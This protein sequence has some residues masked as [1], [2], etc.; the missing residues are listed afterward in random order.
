MFDRDP[1]VVMWQLIMAPRPR[2]AS[3]RRHWW[4]ELVTGV[5]RDARDAWEKLRE[6]EAYFQHELDEFAAEHPP[7]TL[8]SVMVGLSS[9]KDTPPGWGWSL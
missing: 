2:P 1:S 4:R 3:P 7:P 6:S 5:H 8:K 9:G